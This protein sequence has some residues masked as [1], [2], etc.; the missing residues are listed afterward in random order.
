MSQGHIFGDRILQ[1]L[2][3]FFELLLNL[4]DLLQQLFLD[5]L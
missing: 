5:K 4:T 2:I 3:F 1:V